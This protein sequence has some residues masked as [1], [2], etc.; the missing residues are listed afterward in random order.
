MLVP[1]RKNLFPENKVFNRWSFNDVRITDLGLARYICLD[2]MILP[3]SFGR[4][5][6]GK[7]GKSKINLVERLVNKVM[8]SGQGKRKLSGKFIRGR[9]SC[10]KKM[11]AMRIVEGAFEIVE[12]K[13]GKNPVQVLVTAIENTAPREDVTRIKRGGV[14]YTVAVDVSP[15]IRL[16][17]AL[18]NIALAGFGNSF[19]KKVSAAEALAEEMVA[20]STNDTKSSAAKRRDEIERIAKASR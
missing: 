14:P 20:A 9:G 13:T 3:H 4:K 18:K 8:R 11:Q 15:Q 6:G 12:K 5:T 19:N 7:F 1:Q 10:G 16:D 2:S 17:E